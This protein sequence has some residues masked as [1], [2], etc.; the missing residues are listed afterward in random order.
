MA[1]DLEQ[2]QELLSSI[3]KSNAT[4]T[5][6]LHRAIRHHIKN[7][8]Y[9][10]RSDGL[11]YLQVK[12]GIMISYLIDLTMLLRCR[13][14]AQRGNAGGKH[15]EEVDENGRVNDETSQQCI[16]RLLEMKA[17]MEKMR[18]LEKRMRYQIDKLL[19]LSTLGAGTF[20]AV[21]REQ[22]EKEDSDDDG[23]SP[24]PDNEQFD[25]SDPLSFKP[26]L[27]GMMSMFE[28]EENHQEPAGESEDDSEVESKSDDEFN[29]SKPDV[30]LEKEENQTGVY[31]PPRLQAMPFEMNE[32]KH[33]KEERLR[34]IQRD[35][36]QRSELAEVVRAQFTDAP[37]EE[38]IRGGAMLGKQREISKRLAQREAD[39]AE[40]EETHMIRLT[41]GKKEKKERKRIMR[42]EMSNLGAIADLGNVVAGVDDAFGDG[43]RTGR[44]RGDSKG[45]NAAFVTKGM[46]KR[47]VDVLDHE[48]GAPGKRGGR[49]SKGASNSFQKALYGGGRSTG[50]SK[51]KK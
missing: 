46:R 3:A 51:K 44:N 20:A 23:R 30:T 41:M 49:R 27:Q 47:K 32:Q 22:E 14:K 24:D 6:S 18:P 48:M 15:D 37:E 4:V 38:D 10:A 28:D 31:Q 16:Q 45:G 7:K 13:L 35:R 19:A 42:E 40:F 36:M 29:S 43:L 17:A 1:S 25:E 9:D 34:K 11:D 33:E 8:D 50:K 39:V 12:N 26:D 21:G 5:T 2:N